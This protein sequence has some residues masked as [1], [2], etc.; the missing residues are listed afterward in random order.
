MKAVLLFLFC[1]SIGY[2]QTK[3]IAHKSHSGSNATFGKALSSNM[4]GLEASN[5]GN[6]PEYY[7]EVVIDSVVYVS[8]EKAIVVKTSY[9][10]PTGFYKNVK[11][12]INRQTVRVLTQNAKF[13]KGVA[14]DSIKAAA[15]KENSTRRIKTQQTVVTGF[16]KKRK[17]SVLLPVLPN[18]DLPKSMF[19]LVI[20]A[21]SVLVLKSFF[22]I[23][24]VQAKWSV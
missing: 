15:A 1:V 23:R 3:L 5:L 10:V 13:R 6:P 21:L 19:L 18:F 17:K 24:K 4:F 22:R 7:Y 20:C 16:E 12:T 14:Q 8:P 9:E 11:D 2:S